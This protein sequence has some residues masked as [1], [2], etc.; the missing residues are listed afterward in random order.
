M[1]RMSSTRPTQPQP[2]RTERLRAA[3]EEEIFLGRLKPGE[4]LD[5]QALAAR[6]DTSR[7]PVREA[8]RH[9]VAAGLVQTQPKRGTVVASLNI[10]DLVEMFQVMAELEGL[11]ARL[12]AR[13]MSR[14]DVERLRAVH[15]ASS[16]LVAANDPDGFYEVNLELH[17]LIY[18]G[19]QN[20]FLMQETRDIRRRVAFYRRYITYLPGR[21]AGSIDEHEAIIE[22][23]A[24]GDGERAHR[25]MRD[26]VNL[27]GD[28]FSDFISSLRA[29]LGDETVQANGR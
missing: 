1:A 29:R 27:L 17:E 10:A 20:R 11:C 12:A 18:H 6:F 16:K 28:A 13:R 25:L 8:L 4:R 26:H 5:E 14:E 19:S 15:T 24:A 3:I 7:T 21:M 2:T 22:A 23:I 9:L